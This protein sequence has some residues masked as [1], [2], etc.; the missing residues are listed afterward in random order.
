MVREQTPSHILYWRLPDS[1]TCLFEEC[2]SG[3]K[4]PRCGLG[5]VKCREKWTSYTQRVGLDYSW[6]KILFIFT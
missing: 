3:N 6:I 1:T 2:W 5:V 4:H